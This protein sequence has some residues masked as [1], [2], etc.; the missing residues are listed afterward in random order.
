VGVVVS[1][2]VPG[3]AR[4]IRRRRGRGRLTRPIRTTFAG[5]PHVPAREAVKADL[6]FGGIRHSGYG[7]ELLGLGIKEFVNHKLIDVVD[8]NAE[9]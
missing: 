1:G 7:R 4:D 6:P 3:S 8:I 5:D 9:F 2:G